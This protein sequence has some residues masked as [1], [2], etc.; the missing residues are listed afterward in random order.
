MVIA[1]A[2][3][4]YP[5]R[6]RPDDRSDDQRG[7]REHGETL[8]HPRHAD[9]APP[10]R[11]RRGGTAS[12]SRAPVP[13][14]RVRGRPPR[15]VVDASTWSK[16]RPASSASSAAARARADEDVV[17]TNRD[18]RGKRASIA[19]TSLS[20]RIDATTVWSSRSSCS[21]R[22]R[23][24]SGLCA[25]SRISPVAALEA[26]GK[27]DVR[28]RARSR[29]RRTPPPPRGRR[30]C[31]PRGRAR[32]GRR[33]RRAGRRS[34]RRARRRASPWRSPRA[35]RRGRRCARARRS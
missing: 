16:C 21:T 6:T 28:R 1:E 20:A 3:R 2:C 26:P 18:P 11:D 13:R 15:R 8:G 31:G 5:T 14:A 17:A 30:R 4:S 12:P 10:V 29:G 34:R 35:C 22:W 9:T 25:P 19:S 7:E 33:C 27:R 23:A 24:P 32:G